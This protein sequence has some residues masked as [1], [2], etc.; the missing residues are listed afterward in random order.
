M[1][2]TDPN[3]YTALMYATFYGHLDIADLLLSRGADPSL[4]NSSGQTAL[5]IAKDK[6]H[7]GIVEFFKKYENMNKTSKR[8]KGW[9]KL[10]SR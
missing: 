6:E 10:F 5:S 3:G 2:A 4:E 9:K 7:K 8:G 1:D